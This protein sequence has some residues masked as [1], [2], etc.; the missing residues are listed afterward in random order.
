MVLRFKKIISLPAA[1]CP[2]RRC[3]PAWPPEIRRN[4]RCYKKIFIL[5]FETHT[6][7]SPGSRQCSSSCAGTTRRSWTARSACKG[8][9]LKFPTGFPQKNE[10]IKFDPLFHR[11][12][13]LEGGRHH[14]HPLVGGL[15][16]LLLA[17]GLGVGVEAWGEKRNKYRKIYRK[18]HFLTSKLL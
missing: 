13:R 12:A 6:P 10:L 9:K 11:V 7:A 18:K 1:A 17:D 4:C 5:F 15:L 2:C 8:K 14:E 3:P 16:Q